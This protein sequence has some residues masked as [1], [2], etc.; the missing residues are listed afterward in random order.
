M[1]GYGGYGKKKKT[2][3]STSGWENSHFGGFSRIIWDYP[4]IKMGHEGKIEVDPDLRKREGLHT[5]EKL[6]KIYLMKC[7]EYN[8]VQHLTIERIT[9]TNII[10]RNAQFDVLKLDS[11]DVLN[12]VMSKSKEFAPLFE[13]F[14][15]AILNSSIE[16]EVP[17]DEEGQGGGKSEEDEEGEGQ[18]G[19][20]QGGE[21]EREGEDGKEGEGEGEG[22]EGEGQ[23]GQGQE[24]QGQEGQGEG[25]GE[26]G[27]GEAKPKTNPGGWGS[28]SPDFSKIKQL[29]EGMAEQKPFSKWG[30]LGDDSYKPE[31]VPLDMKPNT[32]EYEPT[33]QEKQDAEMILKQLDISF[34]P[35]SDVVKN[36]KM[37]R[38]DTSKIAEVPAGNLSVYKQTLEDQDTKEFAVCVLAD[39]SGSMQ[40][41]RLDIQFSVLNSIYLALSE[42]IPEADLHI[43]GHTDDD[44]PTIHT[45]CSPYSP[46]YLQNIQKYYEIHNCS[47][48]DGVVIEAVHKKIRETTDRPVILIS[49]SDGQPCDDID[50]MKK[51][52]ER[53]RRDQFVTVGIGIHTDYV[54]ELYTYHK[55]IFDLSTMPKEVAH[56]LNQVVKTE[57][58]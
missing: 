27:E 18:E 35:K 5:A 17:K 55:A 15:D 32:T 31:F 40:G 29:I 43:Y 8:L 9:K 45:F 42:I 11:L 41:T 20:G 48:Y 12:A 46:N 51:I 16:V 21:G 44:N 19:Q 36:L 30:S 49:L 53:A 3:W 54:K 1:I 50:N 14:K 10:G 25:E 38:L 23:E 37:G 26:E 34:D 58:Q 52:M 28:S 57:F 24:G 2:F 33:R 22:Q 7:K 47:N 56:I 6:V 13:H 4:Y 39:M